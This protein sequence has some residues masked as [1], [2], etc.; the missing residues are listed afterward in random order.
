MADKNKPELPLDTDDAHEH[1]LWRALGEHEAG[2]PSAALRQD[3]Y[4]NL[5][6][7]GRPTLLDRLHDILGFRGNAGWVTAAACLLV[8]IG[9]GAIVSGGA[10]GGD[11]R[12]EALEQNIALLNRSLILDRLEN[13]APSKRLRGVID[14]ASIA[15][16]DAE[17]AH[18]LLV[19]ATQDRVGSVRSAAINALGPNI[20]APTVGQQLM[21]LLEQAESPIVQLALVDLVLRYGNTTQLDEVLSLAKGGQLHPDLERYVISTLEGETA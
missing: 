14:A 4:R 21:P 1:A 19:R 11:D 3:F 6:M 2:E 13:E 20:N 16:E 7:A 9:A 17:V 12:L 5:E 10:A 15:G 8:G 18:A